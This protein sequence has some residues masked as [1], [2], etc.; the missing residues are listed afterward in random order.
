MVDGIIEAALQDPSTATVTALERVLV[1]L[2]AT[3]PTSTLGYIVFAADFNDWRVKE[4]GRLAAEA[5]LDRCSAQ[6]SLM[7]ASLQRELRPSIRP[8]HLASLTSL[9]ACGATRLYRSNPELLPRGSSASSTPWSPLAIIMN[10][11][12][13]E[14]TVPTSS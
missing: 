1:G 12:I 13:L 4:V 5:A 14:S 2:S 9:T 6:I 11:F 10:A 7:L 3:R 8:F